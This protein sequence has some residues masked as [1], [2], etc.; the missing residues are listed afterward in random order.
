MGCAWLTAVGFGLLCGFLVGLATCY[1][2]PA[3][4][5]PP[6]APPAALLST[7]PPSEG[8][9]AWKEGAHGAAA[10]STPLNIYQEYAQIE[11]HQASKTKPPQNPPPIAPAS[12]PRAHLAPLSQAQRRPFTLEEMKNRANYFVKLP[13][14]GGTSARET[15]RSDA[16]PLSQTGGRCSGDLALLSHFKWG[17]QAKGC[18]LTDTEGRS[19]VDSKGD[20]IGVGTAPGPNHRF[21]MIREPH[22]H[23]LS[24][25]VHCTE[26][27]DHRDRRHFMPGTLAEW[28][29]FWVKQQ[30]DPAQGVRYRDAPDQKFRCYTPMNFQWNRLSRPSKQDLA[31]NFDVVGLTSDFVRS[32]CMMSISILNKVPRRCDCTHGEPNKQP[33]V[34]HK[35]HRVKHHG[36]SYP[37]TPQEDELI[38]ELT[39]HDAQLLRDAEEHFRRKLDEIEQLWQIKICKN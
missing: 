39:R 27:P 21:T 15:L 4:E 2:R 31:A 12:E 5:R 16:G 23:V 18:W 20:H 33:M 22:S 29:K 25:F 6:A 28:L 11:R 1:M 32:T 30:R 38:A 37:T 34:V 3:T 13:K 19:P 36:S 35:V 14:T 10:P 24:M 26:S 8:S 17:G 9:S 7:A